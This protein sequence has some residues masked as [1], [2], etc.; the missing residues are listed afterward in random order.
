M[1]GLG[2]LHLLG[3]Y[4]STGRFGLL[5]TTRGLGVGDGNLGVVFT[6]DRQRVGFGGADTR[7]TQ[8]LGD[9]DVFVTVGLGLTDFTETVLFGDALLG[10]V[11]GLGG[12]FLTERLDVARLVADVGHVDVDQLQTDLSQLSL[13][14][15]ADV[16]QEL[17]A[18]RVDLLDVHRGDDEAQLT[19]EDVG[20]NV[21]NVVRV[22]A[23]QAFGCVGHALRFGGNTDGESAGHIHADVLLT[24]RVGQVTLDGDGREVEEGVVLKHGPDEGGAAVDTACGADAPLFVA[25]GFTVNDQDF[26]RRTAFV[27]RKDR[28]ERHEKDAR[29]H[30]D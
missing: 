14:V 25:T 11:D 28:S 7:V 21:L 23:E 4:G 19:E 1:Q 20:G 10:L 22:L 26:V 5:L 12:G 8:C 9:A 3:G 27:T 24:Q 17:I 2:R 15:G 6:L 13:D 18:V 29:D 16:G 30:Y